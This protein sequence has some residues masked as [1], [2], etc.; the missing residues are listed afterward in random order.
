MIDLSK[1]LVSL[2]FLWLKRYYNNDN[3]LWKFF[4]KHWLHRAFLASPVLRAFGFETVGKSTLQRI[5]PFYRQV[6]NS[7][8]RVK[9]IR[10]GSGSMLVPII[11]QVQPTPLHCVTSILI[12]R[13]LM[14]TVPRKPKYL[15]KYGLS[16][17]GQLYWTHTWASIHQCCFT[18]TALDTSWKIAH[19]VLTT[20]YRLLKFKDKSGP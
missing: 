20:A 12:Y 17:Y 7:W 9:G 11:S 3:A 4:F 10:T 15:T 19:G 1:N 16:S 8:L 13:Q 14:N 2:S 5:P 18:R 6:F